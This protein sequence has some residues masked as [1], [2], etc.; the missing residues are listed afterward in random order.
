MREVSFKFTQENPGNSVGKKSA[1]NAGGP[2]SIPGSGRS[3]GEGIGY[4][5]QYSWASL[6]A[7]IVKN[8]PEM[9]KT[10]V[11]SLGK[12]DTLEEGMATH[13]NIPSWRIPTDRVACLIMRKQTKRMIIRSKRTKKTSW[14]VSYV[15]YT[16][17]TKKQDWVYSSKSMLHSLST[18]ESNSRFISKYLKVSASSLLLIIYIS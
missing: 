2:G 12:E 1:C 10:R 4:P 18:S 15:N 7:Q 13:S 16:S 6:V 3:P 11:W 14:I 8:P 5:F 17:P 9:W